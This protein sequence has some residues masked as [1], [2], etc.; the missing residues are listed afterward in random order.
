MAVPFAF[1]LAA[2]WREDYVKWLSGVFPWVIFGT[3]T[4]GAGIMLGGYWAYGVLGWGG[5]WGWDPVENSSLIPWM[6]GIIL[7]HTM[8]IQKRTGSLSR[9]NFI[10]AILTYVFVVY[11][12]FL[13]RSGILGDSSVHSFLDPGALAYT[14]LV[15]WIAMSLVV[16]FGMV[17]KRWR[18]LKS[19][20]QHWTFWTRES[21][22]AIGSAVMGSS[23]LVILFGTSWP[24]LSHASL[25]SAFYDR[26]NLPL[27]IALALLLGLSLLV[28]WREGSPKDLMKNSLAS[29]CC[30]LV[31]VAVLIVFGVREISLLLF[32]AAS[33]FAFFVNAIRLYRL[34][35]ESYL[36]TGGALAHIGLALLFLGIIGS[37]RYA[38]K[39]TV[40]LPL[41]ETKAV[42]GY[43][44]T[45]AGSEPTQ[46][47]KWKF[48]L[49]VEKDG[50]RFQLEPVMFQ[51]DYNNGLMRNP[52]YASFL[53]RDFYVEPVSLERDEVQ[54]G[55][56]PHNLVQ[57][58]KGEPRR[59][60][61]VLITF[62]RFQMDHQGTED[63]TAGSGFVVGAV[64]EVVRG[65]MSE[66]VVPT[67]LYKEGQS[68][69]PRIAK[70][71]DGAIGLEL[72]SMAVDAGTGA[73][74]VDVN[75]TGIEGL[76]T[77]AQ[78]NSE[79]LI[80]EASVK[81][82]I[83]LV[84]AAAVLMIAGLTISLRSKLVRRREDAE[85]AESHR[86]G[87]GQAMQAKREDRRKRAEE[88]AER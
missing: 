65:K 40:A 79:A 75:V 69:Q 22:L 35:K 46:D 30:A 50:S 38:Q 74:S 2:L 34:A 61:N 43:A 66:I 39:Q 60:G 73:S 53:T 11:S 83:S 58:K 10:L 56:P 52:D 54:Q 47:G 51:S 82:F 16:G 80:V 68:P 29:L 15:V 86:T 48:T 57:L 9:T 31:G 17:A 55:S 24:I 25:E 44:V 78:R 87:G 13:T 21:F 14:L 23:A 64:L 85:G 76:R 41:G 33:L 12:T 84:W 36:Y 18:E 37:G 19:L 45:Y 77:A 1:A 26:T 63:M 20:A 72:W 49:R 67:T 3:I 59:I 70:T 32:A 28:Q 4:L 71:K 27:A 62:V 81:P 8:A 42:L 6:V 7:I 88:L 5:W